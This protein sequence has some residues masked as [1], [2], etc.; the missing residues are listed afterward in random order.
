VANEI[1]TNKSFN[2]IV[3][4][5]AGSSKNIRV[6]EDQQGGF[7]LYTNDS[8]LERLKDWF[9]TSH[10]QRQE[11][12]EFAKAFILDKASNHYNSEFPLEGGIEGVLNG[13]GLL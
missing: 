7:V 5:F 12:R 9:S 1:Q 8:R 13:T 10:A 2:E 11:N 3:N 4:R 6:K